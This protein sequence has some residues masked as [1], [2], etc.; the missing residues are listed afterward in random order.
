VPELPEVETVRRGLAP[1]ME[2]GE[3]VAAQ[4]LRPGLRYP[5]PPHLAEALK[6]RRI[7]AVRRRAKF[8]LIE[9]SGGRTLISHLGMSGS[10]RIEAAQ[11]VVLPPA[12]ELRKHDHVILLVKRPAGESGAGRDAGGGIGDAGGVRS[13]DPAGGGKTAE[14]NSRM[15]PGSGSAPAGSLWRIIYNDPRRF[16][17]LLPADSAQLPQNPLL[18][19]LGVEPLGNEFSAAYLQEALKGRKTP[20]K[21]ALLDQ[22]IIAG[23]GNIYS[24]ESLWR[25]QL[26]PFRA[27]GSLG[28]SGAAAA[29]MAANLA[30]SVRSVLEDAL[31][32]GGSHL[33]NYVQTNGSLGGFQHNF[34]VY[35]RAGKP[36]RRC[37][38]LIE[39]KPIAGRSS[40]YCGNCQK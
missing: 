6:G 16:G 19:D 14:D 39:K 11:S 35:G 26:S 25:A 21:A 37:G 4:L 32:A 5:F 17:F 23:L 38:A 34:Q 12:A 7:I 20:L 10:W 2:G 33:R 22:H 36:C 1:V 31:A 15:P 3:I 8:L 28:E 18:A 40:F 9:L 27:A 30:Q 24:C 13:G 29:Q